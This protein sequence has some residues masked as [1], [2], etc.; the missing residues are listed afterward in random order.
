MKLSQKTTIK[1]L[2]L[3]FILILGSIAINACDFSYYVYEFKNNTDYTINVTV[4]KDYKMDEVDYG[5]SNVIQ[6]G[7]KNSYMPSSAEITVDGGSGSLSFSW[8]AYYESYNEKIYTKVSGNT[9]TF[10]EI[11]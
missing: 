2:M 6:L 8:E 7:G 5:K 9:V 4:N 11:K 3:S 1:C 10:E